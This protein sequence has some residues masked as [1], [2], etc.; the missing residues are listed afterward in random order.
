[1]NENFESFKLLI[2]FNDSD[3]Q[4]CSKYMVG[5]GSIYEYKNNTNLI[6]IS[7]VAMKKMFRALQICEY[8][9]I[10]K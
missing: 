5:F 2:M 7:E 10:Y 9:I 8:I 4:I 3:H 6:Y 1:M